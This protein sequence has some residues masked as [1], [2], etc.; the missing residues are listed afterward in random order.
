MLIISNGNSQCAGSNSP[1][2]LRPS[3][4]DAAISERAASMMVSSLEPSPR[5]PTEGGRS[6]RRWGED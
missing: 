3:L 4:H 2:A 5:Q 1:L 6:H